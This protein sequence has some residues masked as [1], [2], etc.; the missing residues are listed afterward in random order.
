MEHLYNSVVRVERLQLVVTDSVPE[1]DWAQ[2]TDDDPIAN[3]MLQYLRCRLDMQFL[4]PGKDITPAPEAGKAPDRIG[5]MFSYAYAP[6]KAG[7]RFVAIENMDGDIPEPGTFEM[8]VNP[9]RPQDFRKAHHIEVQVI[10]VNQKLA[11]SNWPTSVPTVPE[12]PDYPDEPE[13]PEEP[14]EGP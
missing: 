6:I 12:D 13:E 7:D 11:P 9:D 3:D 4:R 8:R 2:A 10:E 5:V 14:E 1:M